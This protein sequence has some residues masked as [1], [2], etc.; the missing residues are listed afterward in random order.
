MKN[1]DIYLTDFTFVIRNFS[2]YRKY[3]SCWYNE[4]ITCVY[5]AEP[6]GLLGTPCLPQSQCSDVN[7]EC[8]SNVCLCQ[9]EFFESNNICRMST[10]SLYYT[11]KVVEVLTSQ[12]RCKTEQS[13][14]RFFTS[15][16]ILAAG[17]ELCA[18]CC[19]I[20]FPSVLW[21]EV[22]TPCL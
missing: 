9:P 18:N 5:Y 17:V 4:H 6:K 14:S 16:D 12:S 8:R 22:P 20:S 7:A 10:I 2:Q 19:Y 1:S 15:A 11:N 21:H 13:P 3:S